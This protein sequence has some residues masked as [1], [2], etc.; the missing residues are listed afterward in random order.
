M[1]E[2]VKYKAASWAAKILSWGIFLVC[3]FSMFTSQ[4]RKRKREKFYKE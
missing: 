2:R 4:I 1:K 3:A